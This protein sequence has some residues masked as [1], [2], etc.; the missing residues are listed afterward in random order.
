MK[1]WAHTIVYNEENFLW[2]AV[3]SIIDY[4]DKV[5]IWDTGSTDQ[6]WQIIKKLKKDYADKIEIKQ[7]GR[8]SREQHTQQRQKMLE[9]SKCDWILLLDGDEIWWRES[10]KKLVGTINRQDYKLNAI[11]VPF[12]N[13]VG[14]IYHYQSQSA[15]EYKL[16]GRRGHLTIRAINRRIPRLHLDK[17][18]GQE[19]F[20]DGANHLIQEGN[21]KKILFLDAP[22]LHLTHLK[23]SGRNRGQDKLKYD[24]GISFEKNHI[25]P[26][27]FNNPPPLNI[28]SPLTKRSLKYEFIAMLKFPFT[29][30][31]RKVKNLL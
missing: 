14:D 3:K 21:Q 2:Y 17:P 6:T 7:V 5:L 1:I 8:V 26:E 25:Y 19:G 20:F 18:Y 28:P 10:I 22:F 31:N 16:L 23:R 9:G 29:W 11:V 13:A 30:L 15:G 24:L 4:V 12:F 27:V